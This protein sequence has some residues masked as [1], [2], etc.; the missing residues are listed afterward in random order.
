MRLNCWNTKPI[1]SA[2]L[3]VRA[4]SLDSWSDTPSSITRPA[5]MSSRAERQLRSVVLPEPDG[6]ITERNSPSPTVER[7]VA[8][9]VNL[10]GAGPIDL[11]HALSME[12]RT[13][14]VA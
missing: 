10:A 6:P 13:L 14:P 11:P 12:Q 7:D 3:R 9:R 1:D 4:A 8:Q 5:S 2:R